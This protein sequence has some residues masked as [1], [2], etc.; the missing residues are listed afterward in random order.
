[1]GVLPRRERLR[2][3]GLTMSRAEP[4]GSPQTVSGAAAEGK[5]KQAYPLLYSLLVPV[6]AFTGLVL[7]S[8]LWNLQ[9]VAHQATEGARIMARTAFFKDVL[10]RRWNANRGG[11][12]S[13]L[14][15]S[16]LPNPYLDH[17]PERDLTTPSGQRL[18]LINPAYMTRQV[19]ELGEESGGVLGHVTSLDPI[20]SENRPDPWEVKALE[21]FEKEEDE[22]SAVQN[23]AGKPYMRLMRPLITEESCLRCHAAQ[24][25]ELGDVRGG[26]SASVPLAPLQRSLEGARRAIWVSHAAFWLIGMTF[27]GMGFRRAKL[28]GA[29]AERKQA[30]KQLKEHRDHLEELVEERT[31]ELRSTRDELVRKE[32]LAVLGELAGGVGHELRNPMGVISNAVYY[33]K[34]V[35]PDA[36]EKV[37]EYLEMI[38]TEVDSS[39]QIVFDLL[40]LS[41]S[42]T[43]DKE[44]IP[45]SELLA[46][47]LERQPPPEGVEVVTEVFDSLPSLFVDPRQLIQ[48]LRNLVANAYQAMPE[49]GRLAIEAQGDESAVRLS[50]T[51]TGCGISK[52]DMEHLFEPLFT[53]K[54]RGIGLGLAVSRNLMK[55]NGGDIEVESEQG[56]GSTFTLILPTKEVGP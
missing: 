8:H 4:E 10:C 22:Y 45:V 37:K 7:F 34:M 6:L 49:G 35:L 28:I 54:A 1:M 19:H 30:E 24:G 11:V 9:K 48:V 51:D 25:Y 55:V 44:R 14:S 23:I 56:R 32:R 39:E 5:L 41:R 38:S 16:T 31:K 21:A 42:R 53:T 33:L 13:P 15:S 12:Y 2:E 27:I 46:R 26:I 43:A 47:V 17:L 52:E 3:R 36:D 29:L 20:R 50:V 40:D 18:T